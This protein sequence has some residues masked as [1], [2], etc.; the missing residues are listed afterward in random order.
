MKFYAHLMHGAS[1]YYIHVSHLKHTPFLLW[2]LKGEENC[3]IF[4]GDSLIVTLENND[5]EL[6]G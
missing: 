4:K 6:N 1:I 2:I 5:L 3:V